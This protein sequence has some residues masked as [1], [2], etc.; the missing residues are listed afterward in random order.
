MQILSRTAADHL[1]CE[2]QARSLDC[3]LQQEPILIMMP[4]K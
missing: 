3:F 1:K 4:E 2:M